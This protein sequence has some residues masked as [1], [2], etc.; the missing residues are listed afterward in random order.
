MMRLSVLICTYNRSSLLSRSLLKLLVES[1][2]PPDEVVVVVGARDGSDEIIKEYQLMNFPINFFEIDN[3]SLGN[4]QN[5]GLP[6][7]TGDIVA[8]L[9]D[10]AFV[11]P[12]WVSMIKKI[13]HEHPE[14][15]GIGGMI[16]NYY[17]ENLFARFEGYS[18]LP[19]EGQEGKYV[20][21]VAGVNMS[22]KRKAMGKIGFFDEDLPAGMDSDYNWRVL[23]AGYK[24]WYDP[25]IKVKH[26]NRRTLSGVM[27]Q[28]FWYG[29]GYYLT[30]K[31]HPDLYS[32]HPR[33]L[34]RWQDWVKLILFP[35]NIF[36]MPIL[37][38]WKAP[39]MLDK[40]LFIPLIFLKELYWKSGFL[41]QKWHHNK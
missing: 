1:N 38:N 12:N 7:C 35:V 18:G 28:Q 33:D 16:I 22:Y 30:R 24:I 36:I 9:D 6:H 26:L 32:A 20:R 37:L 3:V 17:S 40:L 2:E 23:Q 8:T 29:R 34:S 13:H 27:K 19:Y 25:R 5:Y 21:T 39:H 10:D 4:S 15:G 41:F 11:E 31:K 14:A